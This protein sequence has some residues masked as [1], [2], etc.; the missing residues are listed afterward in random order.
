MLPLNFK[1]GRSGP[2][3]WDLR[4]AKQ[5]LDAGHPLPVGTTSELVDLAFT[6]LSERA[7][8]ARSHALS[9]AAFVA[10]NFDNPDTSRYEDESLPHVTRTW[11]IVSHRPLARAALG[12]FNRVFG[13]GMRGLP[14]GKSST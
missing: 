12:M 2:V 4:T 14:Y 9:R 11:A 10:L 8:F 1:A 6:L 13:I 7:D 5:M 3:L